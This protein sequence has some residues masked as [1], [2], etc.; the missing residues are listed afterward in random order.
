MCLNFRGT[1]LLWFLEFRTPSKNRFIRKYFEQV[2]QN[3][4]KMDAEQF[5]LLLYH[6]CIG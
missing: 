3:R 4:T 1:K 6:L 2:L 5:P